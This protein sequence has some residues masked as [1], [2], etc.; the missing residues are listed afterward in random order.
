[1][2]RKRQPTGMEWP[3]L[4]AETW[5]LGAEASWVIGLRCARLAAGG[6]AAD[7][8][9][10]RMVTEKW[11]AQVELASALATGQFGTDPQRI[12]SAT[13]RH[14]RKRVRAN[15]KRLTR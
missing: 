7:Q 14:Y 1:M 9:S 8:E 3:L 15:R 10:V 12:A 2:T 11:Q 13:V 4:A 6:A 5:W